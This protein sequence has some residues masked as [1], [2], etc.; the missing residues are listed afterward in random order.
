[1]EKLRI[2]EAANAESPDGP[3]GATYVNEN[4][5]PCPLQPR[6]ESLSRGTRHESQ[7]PLVARARLSVTMVAAKSLQAMAELTLARTCP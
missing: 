4:T 6:T 3:V 2:G 7:K 5:P 1:M